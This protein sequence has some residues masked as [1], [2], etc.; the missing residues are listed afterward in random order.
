MLIL[1]SITRWSVV[2]TLPPG[3][4]LNLFFLAHRGEVYIMNEERH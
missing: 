3:R 2:R 4:F 1:V